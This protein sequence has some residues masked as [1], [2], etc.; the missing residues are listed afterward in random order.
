MKA[1]K[2]GYFI[3]PCLPGTFLITTQFQAGFRY[4]NLN[5]S[6]SSNLDNYNLSNYRITNFF[7]RTSNFWLSLKCSY[8]IGQL[9]KTYCYPC[10]CNT[11]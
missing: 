3:P 1:N 10:P 9:L 7:I 4:F 11:V 8:F 5:N 2:T 6:D